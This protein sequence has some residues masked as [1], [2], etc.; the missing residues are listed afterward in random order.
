MSAHPDPTPEHVAL[1]LTA[2]ASLNS[3]NA[4]VRGLGELATKDKKLQ[5]AW[6]RLVRLSATVHTRL[7][8]RLASADADYL[9][10]LSNAS[11]AV[12]ACL[13]QLPA[14]GMEAV[15]QAARLCVEVANQPEAAL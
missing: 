5:A 2:A 15:V 9:N 3:L 4:A 10:S 1:L 8:L 6:P 12:L 11:E 14:A 13:V 7:S